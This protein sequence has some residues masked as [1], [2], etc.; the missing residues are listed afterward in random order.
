MLAC[1]TYFR[2][3]TRFSLLLRFYCAAKP[4]RPTVA[5]WLATV[6]FPPPSPLG[7]TRHRLGHLKVPWRDDAVAN[8]GE[9]QWQSSLYAINSIWPQLHN[10]CCALMLSVPSQTPPMPRP[11]KTPLQLNSRRRCLRSFV[12]AY[13]GKINGQFVGS[14]VCQPRK[15]RR[16]ALRFAI[17]HAIC[18]KFIAP[19]VCGR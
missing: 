11:Q 12:F 16:G 19:H 2:V 17:Y 6:P 4:F 8:A 10:V 7:D 9:T 18:G 15:G 3:A 13:S 1:L 14:S 5:T